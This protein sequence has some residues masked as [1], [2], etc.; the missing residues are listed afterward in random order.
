MSKWKIA[1]S[2][3]IGIGLLLPQISSGQTF[4]IRTAATWASPDVPSSSRNEFRVR[5]S[6]FSSDS[7]TCVVQGLPA[8][9]AVNVGNCR[10]HQYMDGGFDLLLITLNWQAV[11]DAGTLANFGQFIL[12]NDF[13]MGKW[14]RFFS[15]DGTKASVVAAASGPAR[16]DPSGI[17]LVYTSTL[18]VDRT[19]AASGDG[20]RSRPFKTIDEAVK[21]ARP[22]TAIH[23]AAG[24]YNESVVIYRKNGIGLFG[25]ARDA[26]RISNPGGF[27]VL[28]NASDIALYNLTLR[29]SKDGAGMLACASEFVD[30]A[31]AGSS[32][33]GIVVANLNP[34]DP[35]T[36]SSLTLHN[37]LLSANNVGITV[38]HSSSL[39]AYGTAFERNVAHGVQV[40]SSGTVAL[41]A[42]DI[43]GTEG[44]AV[45]C[46]TAD[47]ITARNL[48]LRDNSTGIGMVACTAELTDIAVTGSSQ[49]GIIVANLD[50]ADP[51]TAS[52]LTLHRSLLR[53][54]NV[55][56]LVDHTSS[57]SAYGTTFEENASHGIQV[58]GPGAVALDDCL[59]SKNE[60]GLNWNQGAAGTRNYEEDAGTLMVSYSVISDN[61][62]AG[63]ILL[64]EVNGTIDESGIR[65]NGYRGDFPGNGLEFYFH[66]G[67]TFT[68][69][70]ST[71]LN[72]A[73]FGIFI[74]SGAV[75]LENNVIDGN[76]ENGMG[77]YHGCGQRRGF[78]NDCTVFPI[79]V[80]LRDNII[81]N[82]RGSDI[83]QGT[84]LA[85]TQSSHPGPPMRVILEGGNEFHNNRKHVGC[86]EPRNKVALSC[87]EPDFSVE[88]VRR[89]G[90][91]P[92]I[93]TCAYGGVRGCL[94]AA[95][96]PEFCLPY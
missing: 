24:T 15:S 7:R 38:N 44:F 37:A 1:A 45:S 74:A 91:V 86:G 78:T 60:Y 35:A 29:G 65:E 2:L 47:N 90:G 75:L 82:N 64:S 40:T 80:V 5:L 32:R 88:G 13:G 49:S 63:I 89:A 56:I 25:A 21:A 48:T 14:V 85:L 16:S 70:N 84:G 69:S 4:T 71:F 79:N 83:T 58:T 76:G 36:A 62:R 30:I 27:A 50:S 11:G 77:I 54:N 22:R 8:D 67:E 26:V 59:V 10:W 23:I 61:D 43:S 66:W 46:N 94:D 18:F 92:L 6:G 3:C 96:C 81:R 41:N 55:G 28:C 68:I 20:T 17:P 9:E 53:A 73:S 72:N 34:A 19:V 93:S 57:L 39:S 95:A 31:V 52:S 12:L 51:A 87:E 33:N 42:C